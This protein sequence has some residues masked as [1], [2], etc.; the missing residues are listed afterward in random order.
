MNDGGV[1]AIKSYVYYVN[2]YCIFRPFGLWF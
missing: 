1:E 2:V